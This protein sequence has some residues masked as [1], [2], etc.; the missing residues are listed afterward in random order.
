MKFSKT[1]KIAYISLLI[2]LEVV[3]GRFAGIMTPIVSINFSFLPLV[4]NAI[5]FGPVSAT[6]SAA[7]SD[8][9]GAFL[10]PQGLGIYFPGFTLSAALN[11]LTYGLLLH[12]KP[13]RLWR[14]CIAC[15]ITNILISLGLS[16]YWVYMM[17]GKG[18][19][20]LLPTRI[21]QNAIMLPIKIIVI[22]LVVYRVIPF[23]WK[24]A[25]LKHNSTKETTNIE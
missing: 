14:I 20:A 3:M 13:L 25:I 6:V 8:I 21:L 12:R 4:V 11:G 22:K 1:Q 10:F 7:I 17:T 5:V 9:L 2:A 15:F 18:F 16:T 24:G 23:V 19:L